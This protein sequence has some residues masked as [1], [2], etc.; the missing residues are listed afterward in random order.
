MPEHNRPVTLTADDSIDE[1]V[2]NE[3]VV[4]LEFYTNGCGICQS[5]EPVLGVVAKQTDAVVATSNPRDGVGIID[6]YDIRGVPTLILFVDGEEVE[7]YSDGFIGADDIREM[8]ATHAPDA[9][10]ADSEPAA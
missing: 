9:V 6:E 4:L 8:I 1:L 7:R 5:M 10:P 3:D 2:A